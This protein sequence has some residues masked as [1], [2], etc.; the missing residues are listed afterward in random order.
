MKKRLRK[1][2][3]KRIVKPKIP[4][5]SRILESLTGSDA[6]SILRILADSD[7]RLA[8][9]IDA[10]AGDLLGEVDVAGMAENVKD[11]LESLDVDDIFDKSGAQ[12]DE[13]VD[14]G[15][16]AF[17]MF[18]EALAPFLQDIERYRTLGLSEQASACCLGILQGIYDFDRDSS[19]QYKDWAVDAPEEYFGQVT[20]A[21]VNIHHGKPPLSKLEGF[22]KEHCPHYAEVLARHLRSRT[23]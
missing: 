6:L 15:E 1:S 9:E 3:V 13:Y 22:V 18:E 12:R 2:A 19:T 4:S 23:R 17:Q 14:P 11:E 5:R 7:E 10:V 21:W 8:R 20:D 16:A